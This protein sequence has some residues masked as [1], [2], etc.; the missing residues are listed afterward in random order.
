MAKITEVPTGLQRF[1][2]IGAHT[3]IK[4]LG[5][6]ENLKAVKLRMVWLDR[7]KLGKQPA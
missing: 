6:D 5:L 7:R 2:R 4:G 3:H 1:E